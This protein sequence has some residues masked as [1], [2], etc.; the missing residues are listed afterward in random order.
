MKISVLTLFPEVFGSYFSASVPGRAQENGLF[1]MEAVNIRDYA[2]NKH[3]HTDDAPFGGGAGMVMMPQP[4]FDCIEDVK[5]G[6]EKPPKVVF[7]SPCGRVLDNKLARSLSQEDGLIIL[8]GHYEGMDQR[9]LD[10]LVD[11]EV[12]IG[13]YV[14]TG[15]ELAAM[16]LVDSMIRFI[17]GVVGNTDVHVEES[18]ENGLLEYPHYTRPAEFRGMEVPP[19]LLSGN[20]AAIAKWR[21]QQSILKTAKCRPDLLQGDVLTRKERIWLE[22]ELSEE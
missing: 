17:P 1:S 14:L 15:G 2:T 10:E 3:K 4:V 13:D 11:M 18:F 8:C 21:R 16:V 7:M 19:V 9:V 6:Y 5:K 20:H 22:N 12:S